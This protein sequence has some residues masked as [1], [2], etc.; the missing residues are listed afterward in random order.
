MEQDECNRVFEK[1]FRQAKNLWER[2]ISKLK[3]TSDPEDRNIIFMD[4][5][6]RILIKYQ[7]SISNEDSQKLLKAFPGRSEDGR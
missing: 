5:F 3:R 1:I 7:V 2:L 4:D 6:E